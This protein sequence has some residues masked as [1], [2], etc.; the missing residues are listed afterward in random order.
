L[1]HV[2]NIERKKHAEKEGKEEFKRK[3]H[4]ACRQTSLT[5]IGLGFFIRIVTD[6]IL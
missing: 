5:M 6:I 1:E 3:S 4:V 2:Q